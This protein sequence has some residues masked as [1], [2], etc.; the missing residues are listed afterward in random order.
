MSRL[1]GKVA[2]VTGG[3]G[4][5]GRAIVERFQ[6]EGARVCV[7]DRERDHSGADLR[8]QADV[9]DLEQM[10]R[11]VDE[12]QSLGPLDICVANAGVMA[13]EPFTEASPDIW[14]RIVAVNLIGVLA[15]FQAAVVPMIKSQRRGRLLAT[16]STAGLR[17]QAGSAAYCASKAGVVAV[18]QSLAVEFAEHR[19][20]VNAVAP[21]EIDT[22]MNASV[23]EEIGRREGV[24]ADAI[25]S[26]L[27]ERE[28]PARRMGDPAE[29]AAVFAF[30]ASDDADYVTGEVI[31]VDGGQLNV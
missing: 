14:N 4:G 29:V 24:S 11:A 15:T 12:A 5:I 2:L 3:A 23:M 18:V 8:I 13:Y 26:Q 21:G 16:S 7:V 27:L 25:R 17:A 30:L 31:R 6:S 20:T 28:I 22:S 9:S 10:T 1:E 19:I